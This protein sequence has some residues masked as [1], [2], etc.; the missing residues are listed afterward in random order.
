MEEAL[1]LSF[2]KLLLMMTLVI[3]TDILKEFNTS[4]LRVETEMSKLRSARLCCAIRGH[5]CKFFVYKNRNG[6][7]RVT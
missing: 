1:D 6:S 2:D 3:F 7:E 4:I 5:I